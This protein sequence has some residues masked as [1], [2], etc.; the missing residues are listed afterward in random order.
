MK[1]TRILHVDDNKDE[2]ELIRT[3]IERLDGNIELLTVNSGVSALE[4]L[5]NEAVDC[6]I[7]DYRMPG[8][9]GLELLQLLR[10]RDEGLPVVILTSEGDEGVRQRAIDM[11]ADGYFRKGKGVTDMVHFIDNV[12]RI[13]QQRR[14]EQ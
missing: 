1:R 11:G 5:T 10:K 12:R 14:E 8:M 6:V 7:S 9:D 2:L 4:T 13:L 3:I